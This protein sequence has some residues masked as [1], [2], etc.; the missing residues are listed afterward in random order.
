[1][2][3]SEAKEAVDRLFDRCEEID[4]ESGYSMLDDIRALRDYIDE[5]DNAEEWELVYHDDHPHYYAH[6]VTARCPKCGEWCF[7]NKELVLNKS[8][9]EYGVR[10]W[11]GFCTN[12]NGE[13]NKKRFERFALDCAESVRKVLPKYCCNCGA[14]LGK[15]G[16]NE[17]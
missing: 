3:N 2:T 12:Y 14:R 17:S 9:R 13:E 10:L 1:M 4:R 16:D 15:E 11:S 5:R 6:Y 7:G 8:D